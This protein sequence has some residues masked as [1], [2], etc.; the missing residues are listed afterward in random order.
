METKKVMHFIE[1]QRQTRKLT[2]R[3]LCEQANVSEHTYWRYIKGLEPPFC[4][5]NRLLAVLNCD[6]KVVEIGHNCEITHFI[7]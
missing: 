1:H 6:I 2:K 3:Y 5:V 4:T 7:K